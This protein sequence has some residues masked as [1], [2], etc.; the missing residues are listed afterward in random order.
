MADLQRIISAAP[1]YL[2]SGGKLLL[3]HGYNQAELV[4]DYLRERGFVDLGSQ[5]DYGGNERISWGTW[6]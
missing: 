4:R 1:D 3:E 5:V 6:R 2:E